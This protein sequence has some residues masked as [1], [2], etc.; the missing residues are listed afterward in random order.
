MKKITIFGF[1]LV[2]FTSLHARADALGQADESK[3]ALTITEVNVREVQ[4]TA[5]EL[6]SLP[7]TAMPSPDGLGGTIDDIN[8]II[9]IGTKIYDIIKSNAPVVNVQHTPLS[10]V[11]MGITNWEQLTNWRAPMIKVYE[12]T[13]KNIFGMTPVSIRLKL[14]ANYGGTYRGHGKFL[15]N[16]DLVTTQV[17]VWWGYTVDISAEDMTP[18]NIGSYG[19]PIAALPVNVHFRIRTIFHDTT[20]EENYWIDGAGGFKAE[21]VLK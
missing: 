2:L 17:S 21:T 3:A 14:T 20:G 1:C 13:A 7:Q 8:Q 6:V 15:A 18:L 10:V 12:I 4:P 9:E 16:V 11:P 5:D 19:A